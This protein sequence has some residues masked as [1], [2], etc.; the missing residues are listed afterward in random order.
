MPPTMRTTRPVLAF[1]LVAAA[2]VAAL[3]L[4]GC[5]AGEE[6]TPTGTPTSTED[7]FHSPRELDSYRY[8]LDLWADGQILDQSEAPQGLGLEDAVL[9]VEI[10][11]RWAAPGSEYQSARVSF[12]YLQ[13]RQDSVTIDDRIWTSTE[14]GAWHQRETLTGPEAFLGQD[15]PLSPDSIFGPGDEATLERLKADMA[16]RPHDTQEVN[17]REAEHWVLDDEWFDTYAADFAELLAG[18]T[19]GQ[20]IELRIEVW[21]DTETGV[22]TK[23]QVTGT[24][25]TAREVMSLDMTLFDLNDPDITVEEPPGAIGR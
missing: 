14:G 21:S 17:G 11:G 22:G 15:V 7:R 16:L 1:A 8:T 25:P 20:G 18:I 3:A 12:G 23:L 19:R 2:S 24:D 4:L 5:D 9:T 13:A 6:E 10:E